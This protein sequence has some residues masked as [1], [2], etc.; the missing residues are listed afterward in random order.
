MFSLSQIES[1]LLVEDSFLEKDFKF[2]LTSKV[3]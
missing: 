3:F 2:E 1:I